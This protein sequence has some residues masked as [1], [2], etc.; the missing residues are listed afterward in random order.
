MK[1]L[2]TSHALITLAVILLAAGIALAFQ[3]NKKERTDW[4]EYYWFDPD[5]NYLFRQ[6]TIDDEIDL[7]GYDESNFAPFTLREKGFT[8]S[9]VTGDPPIPNNPYLPAKKLYT[10]P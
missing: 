10:H 6:N 4:T 1:K 3:K 7:T 8:P 5:G 2:K 9:T